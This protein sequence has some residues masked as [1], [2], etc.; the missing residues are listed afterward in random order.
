MPRLMPPARS[1]GNHYRNFAIGV[2][3]VAAIMAV[4]SEGSNGEAVVP[5]PA[6]RAAASDVTP[7]ALAPARGKTTWD[8]GGEVAEA[9]PEIATLAEDEADAPEARA[10][11]PPKAGKRGPADRP[12]PEQLAML[13]AAS[14][15][16]SG[17]PPDGD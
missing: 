13:V 12:T 1:S 5:A 11:A 16:R 4:A 6:G 3:A 8:T 14:R 17:A 7:A 10:I 9:A 2:M 15:E